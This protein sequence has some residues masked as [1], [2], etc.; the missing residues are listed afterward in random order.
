MKLIIAAIATL[1]LI[2]FSLVQNVEAFDPR[3][4][5]T[6]NP[7]VEILPWMPHY[8]GNKGDAGVYRVNDQY[9]GLVVAALRDAS[10]SVKLYVEIDG[11]IVNF[12][13]RVTPYESYKYPYEIDGIPAIVEI[14]PEFWKLDLNEVS[15]T[16]F[17]SESYGRIRI[18]SVEFIP[19]SSDEDSMSLYIRSYENG[20]VHWP[21]VVTDHLGYVGLD[22]SGI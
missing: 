14:N 21:Q 15:E 4:P 10:R 16:Y 6:D 20:W 9:I 1:T 22:R 8:E 3:N 13:C 17:L 7:I 11:N 18:E 12:D 5:D 19:N 2:G